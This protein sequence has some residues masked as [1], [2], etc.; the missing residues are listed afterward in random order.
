MNTCI[1]GD[2]EASDE[3]VPG[4]QLKTLPAGVFTRATHPDQFPPQDDESEG[5]DP[6]DTASL[7][8]GKD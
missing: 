4:N 1:Q 3:T 6:Y 8:V 2:T 7:F 5:F